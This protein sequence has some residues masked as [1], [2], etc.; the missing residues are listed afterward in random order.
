MKRYTAFPTALPAASTNHNEVAPSAWSSQRT[1]S[2]RAAAVVI[3]AV[4]VFC[5]GG[6][7]TASA[8]VAATGSAETEAV[9]TRSASKSA[10]T[11]TTVAGQ[12]VTVDRATGKLRPPTPEEARR[13]AEGMQKMLNRSSDGL[14]V[15]EHPDGSKSVNLEGR[16]Q[17]LSVGKVNSDGTVSTKCVTNLNEAEAFVGTSL[18]TLRNSTGAKAATRN[19]RTT[20]RTAAS[21]KKT[22]LASSKKGSRKAAR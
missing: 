21:S 15:V 13:L 7:M 16:F 11:V 1:F 14:T 4:F 19:A 17:S 5:V 2:L 10:T 18:K 9:E 12:Q 3:T 6:E 20:T 22:S 8:Q